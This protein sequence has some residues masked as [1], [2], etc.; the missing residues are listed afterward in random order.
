M[1]GHGEIS[2]CLRLPSSSL[3]RPQNELRRLKAVNENLKE[4]QKRLLPEGGLTQSPLKEL[5]NMRFFPPGEEEGTS[6][7]APNFSLGREEFGT[8][9]GDLVMG[10][11][12]AGVPVGAGDSGG[13]GNG[14][15]EEEFHDFGDVISSQGEINRLQS[16]LARVRVECQ[17][18]RTLAKEKVM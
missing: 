17:H 6:L 15:A 12:G 10:D 3:P 4:E 1:S 11:G 7:S 14:W 16:E 5:A 13:S 2:A 18:W 9:R 8:R